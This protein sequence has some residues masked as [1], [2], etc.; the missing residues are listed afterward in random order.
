MLGALNAPR[1]CRAA[2][3]FVLSAHDAR[4]HTCT[5]T[6][7]VQVSFAYIIPMQHTM[8]K[9]QFLIP[10]Y[11]FAVSSNKFLIPKRKFKQLPDSEV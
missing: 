6:R 4:T 7:P 11:K 1:G 10:K 2:L 5:R 9:E 3:K 8:D